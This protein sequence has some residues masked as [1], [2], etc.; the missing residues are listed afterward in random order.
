MNTL[1]ATRRFTVVCFLTIFLT[2]LSFA[3]NNCGCDF[4]IDASLA[5]GISFAPWRTGDHYL[6]PK[7]GQTICLKGNYT[8]LRLDGLR[9]TAKAPII[10]KNLCNSVASFN[11]TG[12]NPPFSLS[13]CEYIHISGASNPS[14]NYGISIDCAASAGLSVSGT[15][16]N[17]IEIDHIEVKKSNF[18]GFMIKQDPTCDPK[19][20][21]DSMTMSNIELHHNYIHDV[22]GEGFYIGNS[23]WQ[24]GMT[25]TCSG[26][27]QVVYPHRILGL[28]VHHN[29]VRNTGWD[30][31][32]Y[33][34]SPDAVVYNNLIENTG[35]LKVAQQANGVQIGAGSGGLFYNNVIRNAS[36]TGVA[37]IGFASTTKVYNN[38]II[39]AY[40]GIFADTRDSIKLP[41]I[42]LNIYNNTLINVAQNGMTIYDNG[43]QSKNT[44]NE[45]TFSPKGYQPRVKNNVIIGAYFDFRLILRDPN[46]RL[47]SSNNYKLKTPFSS[48][49]QYFVAQKLALFADTVSYQLKA[50]SYL[51]NKGTN[52]VAGV[53]ST[54]LLGES[55]FQDA[56]FDI[57]AYEF[58]EKYPIAQQPTITAKGL[59]TYRLYPS[60]ANDVLTVDL[61]K[62]TQNSVVTIYNLIG[63]PFRSQQVSIEN[64]A[65]SVHFDV[66]NLQQGSYLCVLTT[67]NKVV[68]SLK[69]AKQ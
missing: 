30:G 8:D 60:V 53:V 39:N 69:F 67:D 50:N 49:P 56:S 52:S 64:N 4:T 45:S 37:I 68:S 34:C 27:N 51:I 55:R 28:K 22:A 16:A 15:T 61:P 25:R 5:N 33:G 58:I 63:Q 3:Q 23:F 21:R 10:I 31:I 1:F 9:G 32:Q 59:K 42:E 7:P 41:K 24:G 38:L 11:S 54:D 66:T 48:A 62:I 65:T 43:F 2:S 13:N 26:Q 44:A 20:W 36:G 29:T 47:D 40:E 57:G 19:T 35:L 18:A 12:S 14:V 6:N 46:I 17:N